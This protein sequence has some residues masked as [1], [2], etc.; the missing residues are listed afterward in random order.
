[1]KTQINF[2]PQISAYFGICIMN[3]DMLA[4]I[5]NLSLTVW[6]GVQCDFEHLKL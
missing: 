6:D 2:F 5:L 1:M 4:Y 3:L